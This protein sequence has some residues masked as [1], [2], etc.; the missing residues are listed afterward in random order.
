MRG[1]ACVFLRKQP[2]LGLRT[3]KIEMLGSTAF[4][5][6]VNL[7]CGVLIELQHRMPHPVLHAQIKMEIGRICSLLQTLKGCV[8]PRRTAGSVRLGRQG[9]DTAGIGAAI[10]TGNRDPVN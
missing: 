7:P 6:G 10:D 5:G 2:I 4:M 9:K 1:R 8:P 3:Q